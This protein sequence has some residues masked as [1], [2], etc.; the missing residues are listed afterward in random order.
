MGFTFAMPT[1][2]FAALERAD[3]GVCQ[4]MIDA[5]LPIAKK[6]IRTKLQPHRDTGALAESLT[7]RKAKP[8]KRGDGYHGEVVPTG[9]DRKGV[10]NG[11]KLAY[12]EYGNSR[13][14]QATPIV[15]PAMAAVEDEILE[16]MQR[17]YNAAVTKK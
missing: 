9:T 8:F 17:V 11:A 10:R 12:L 4:Q 6:S 16:T 15:A 13:H 2:L 7:L 5:A 14:Q 3:D 1:E